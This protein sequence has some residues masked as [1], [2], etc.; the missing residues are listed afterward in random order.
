MCASQT[1]ASAD[2]LLEAYQVL[3]NWQQR[4]HFSPR[5]AWDFFAG[6]RNQKAVQRQTLTLTLN[7]A[8]RPWLP[9]DR[10]LGLVNPALL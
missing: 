9:W 2:V 10:E 5:G 8:R 4:D 7:E 3:P 1:N 6:L